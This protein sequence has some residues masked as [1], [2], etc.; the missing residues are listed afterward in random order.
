[1]QQFLVPYQSLFRKK[2]MII[3]VELELLSD[4]RCSELVIELQASEIF[5][6]KI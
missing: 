4:F 1:M 6:F 5:V 2:R 3:D